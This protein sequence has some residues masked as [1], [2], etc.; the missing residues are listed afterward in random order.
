VNCVNS[1]SLLLLVPV[2]RKQ[3]DANLTPTKQAVYGPLV[4]G[5]CGPELLHR[6]AEGSLGDGGAPGIGAVEAV[7]AVKVILGRHSFGVKDRFSV[8][9][10]GKR[11]GCLLELV[12]CALGRVALA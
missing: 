1:V 10:D 11:V 8:E 9:P 5:D 7:L 3:G 6:A 12:R 4:V 2:P